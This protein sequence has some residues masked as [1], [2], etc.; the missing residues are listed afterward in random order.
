MANYRAIFYKR[1]QGLADENSNT[2]TIFT[3]TSDQ[4]HNN[5]LRLG[6]S[7]YLDT[8]KYFPR[9]ASKF[10]TPKLNSSK[11]KL[12]NSDYYESME[13]FSPG[14]NGRPGG[15]GRIHTEVKCRFNKVRGN[16]SAYIVE[17]SWGGA[18][19]G[20]VV[21]HDTIDD[22]GSAAGSVDVSDWK[23]VGDVD[24]MSDTTSATSVVAPSELTEDW[25]DVGNN[26]VKTRGFSYAD[27][28]KK[29][30]FEAE[31][32]QAPVALPPVPLKYSIIS[33]AKEHKGKKEDDEDLKENESYTDY[34]GAKSM[35]S[36]KRPFKGEGR[37]CRSSPYP[38]W[39]YN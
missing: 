31:A 15:A 10:P 4:A 17:D 6:K 27:M 30:S 19:G 28:L 14:W 3:Y 20:E 33:A 13:R 26:S 35:M 36:G 34:D 16:A 7:N 38:K 37:T 5:C 18:E 39:F 22:V 24:T 25:V 8:L 9:E 21:V 32:R 23:L 1:S 2:G 11:P 12:N 29:A